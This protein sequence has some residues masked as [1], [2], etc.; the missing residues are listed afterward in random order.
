MKAI[1]WRKSVYMNKFKCN[2]CGNILADEQGNPT[3]NTGFNADLSKR[4]D[5]L[6][7]CRCRNAVAV[8][9][10]YKGNKKPGLHGKWKGNI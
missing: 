10:D 7:C 5:I 2:K 8:I 6:Y 9:K 3:D 1:I 4:Q